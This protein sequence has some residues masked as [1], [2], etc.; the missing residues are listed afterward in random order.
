MPLPRLVSINRIRN[1]S[2]EVTILLWPGCLTMTPAV[3]RAAALVQSVPTVTLAGAEV[4]MGAAAASAGRLEAPCAIAV[5]DRSGTPVAFESLDGVRP[6]SAD[7]AIGK[8]HAAA[9]LQRPTIE[10]E[11]NT[12]Q[13]RTAF[14]TAGLLALQDGAPLREGDMVVGA[15]GIAGINRDNDVRIADEAA[16]AFAQEASQPAKTRP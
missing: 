7:L 4:A 16:A 9:L 15:I 10:I 8:A 13:G 3:C 12:N 14:V 2:M 1:L 11:N 5:V 6:G